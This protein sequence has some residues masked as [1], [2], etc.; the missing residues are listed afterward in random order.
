MHCLLFTRKN[1]TEGVQFHE[2]WTVWSILCFSWEG[3]PFVSV[4]S[5]CIAA[6]FPCPLFRQR[7]GAAVLEWWATVCQLWGARPLDLKVRCYRLGSRTQNWKT[8]EN[9]GEPLYHT[10]SYCINLANDPSWGCL[11]LTW[12]FAP[13]DCAPTSDECVSPC[14]TTCA[15]VALQFV[16]NPNPIVLHTLQGVR[17]VPKL[18]AP[19][20]PVADSERYSD[21]SLK[22]SQEHHSH[23]IHNRFHSEFIHYS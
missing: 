14:V 16:P 21:H 4:Y 19:V 6:V 5:R 22:M 23:S 20:T 2:R 8:M 10:E 11:T 15:V 13:H 17:I 3:C 12:E 18:R 7:Q 1:V 9:H